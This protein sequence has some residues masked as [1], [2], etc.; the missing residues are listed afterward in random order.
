ME[1]VVHSLA[2]PMGL[3]WEKE[4]VLE[5]GKVMGEET[6]RDDAGMGWEVVVVLE[7]GLELILEQPQTK[8]L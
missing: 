2:R 8:Y 4:Q 1:L 7:L 3:A 5:R 6:D